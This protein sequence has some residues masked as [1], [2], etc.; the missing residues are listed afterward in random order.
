MKKRLIH[1]FSLS[2][3]LLLSACVSSKKIEYFQ[4]NDTQEQQ[5]EVT[6]ED[7]QIQIGDLINITITAANNEAAIPFNLYTTPLV[8]ENSRG[9]PLPYLVDTDGQINFP[10]LGKLEIVGLTTKALTKKLEDLLVGYIS[11]PVIN[12][13]FA[14]FRI[15]VLGE[16]NNPGAYPILNEH[17][18]IIEA[19]SLA[20]DLTTYGKRESILLIRTVNGEKTQVN[21]D[22]TKEDILNSPYFY[23]RQNDIIYVAPNKTKVNSTRVGPNTSVI[24]STISVLFA[25][26]AILL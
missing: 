11:D 19:I 18:S 6:L 26:I 23:L 4:H 13:R 25:V 17:M 20:G 8:G 16:V 21:L 3:I 22:L 14:N 7:P 5:K 15:S 12:I 9:E 10:I 24:F 1:L 2:C